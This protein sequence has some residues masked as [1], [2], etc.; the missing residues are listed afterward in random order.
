MIEMI[1]LESKGDFS[2]FQRYLEKLKGIMKL[3]IFD[4]CGREGVEALRRNT[5]KD[6]GTTANSWYYEVEHKPNSSSIYW[7]NSHQNKGV[8]IAIILQYGHGTGNGYYVEGI[9]YINPAL[10]SVFDEMGERVWKE[11]SSL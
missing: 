4:E 6:T 11:I 5:P 2:K 1:T 7:C 10:R 3:S 8:N 9:D